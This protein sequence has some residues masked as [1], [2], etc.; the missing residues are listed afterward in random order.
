MLPVA[1]VLDVPEAVCAER[2]AARPD[3]DFG[4]HVIRNQRTPLRRSLRDLQREGFRR[5]YVLDGV[6]DIEAATIEREPLLDRPARR[7]GPFD[8]IGDVH[9]CHDELVALLGAARLHGRA[10]TAP[11]PRHPDGRRAVF[12]GDL[13][14]R[15]P[16]TPG[17]LRLVMG[18]VRGRDRRSASP[19]TT[20]TSCCGR[21]GAATSR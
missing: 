8:I 14:D 2:N 5:V 7:H 15:G 16:A 21:C 20:R 1:I 6:E 17:V 18:M 4:A 12:V 11:S 10:P 13:V 19:A 9:G 3:R